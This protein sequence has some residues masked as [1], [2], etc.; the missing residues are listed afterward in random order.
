MKTLLLSSTR[1]A[2]LAA[3]L[4][5]ISLQ[6]SYGAVDARGCSTCKTECCKKS[7]SECKKCSADQ[8]KSCCK[9]K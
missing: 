2:L 1:A 4:G 6:A 7:C 3:V 8:C 5:G 9:K